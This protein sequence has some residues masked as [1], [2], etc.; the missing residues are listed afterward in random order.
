METDIRRFQ[1]GKPLGTNRT[2]FT[3]RTTRLHLF[4]ILPS[5][6][7]W[8]R[9]FKSASRS[10]R[11]CHSARA[12]TTRP[13]SIPNWRAAQPITADRRSV[14][15]PLHKPH[16]CQSW[17]RSIQFVASQPTSF[18]SILILYSRLCLSFPKDLFPWDLFTYTLYALD[19][20]ISASVLALSISFVS[21]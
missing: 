7:V 2:F 16:Y 1:I 19:S 3:G 8:T 4:H 12:R 14:D 18:K 15:A 17:E 11:I 13:P 10:A 20:S 21:F 9:L 5:R 6:I